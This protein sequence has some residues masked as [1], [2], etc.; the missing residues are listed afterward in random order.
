M[1]GDTQ[2]LTARTE[3]TDRPSK[4]WRGW[5]GQGGENKADGYDGRWTAKAWQGP[6]AEVIQGRG[7]CARR[8]LPAGTG[9]EARPGRMAAPETRRATGTSPTVP[10]RPRGSPEAGS[11]RRAAQL[12]SRGR[13][14][15]MSGTDAVVHTHWFCLRS[16][17]HV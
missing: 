17:R 3:N 9:A 8:A 1:N 4:P 11:L 14:F 5:G 12:A 13:V 6:G 16:T 2:L 15:C 7:R 10:A